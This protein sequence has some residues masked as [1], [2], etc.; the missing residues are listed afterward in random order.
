MNTPMDDLKREVE[1]VK[2]APK[3]AWK[4]LSDDLRGFGFDAP[5]LGIA[6][7]FVIAVVIAT[8]FGGH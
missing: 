2:A 5:L 6:A 8:Y 7:L 3:K 1:D 4:E